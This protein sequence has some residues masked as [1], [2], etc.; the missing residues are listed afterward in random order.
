MLTKAQVDE[1]RDEI[2]EAYRF[3]QDDVIAA[4]EDRNP[5]AGICTIKSLKVRTAKQ[6]RL[7]DLANTCQALF[8]ETRHLIAEGVKQQARADAAEE[9]LA[10]EQCVKLVDYRAGLFIKD[11]PCKCATC[12]ARFAVAK[13]KEQGDESRSS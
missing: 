13:R 2:C 1:L 6:K 9:A 8:E 3:A 11:D 4:E 7:V 5:P 10:K 12:L